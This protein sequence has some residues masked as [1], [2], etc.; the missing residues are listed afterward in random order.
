MRGNILKESNITKIYLIYNDGILRKK[1]KAKLRYMD[2]SECFFATDLPAGF[3]KPKKKIPVEIQAFT[4]DG[5]YKT[6]L[7][8]LDTN[9]TLREAIFQVTVPDTWRF[10]QL[11]NGSRMSIDLSVKVAFDDGFTIETTT[12]DVSINGFAFFD[13]KNLSSIYK[14]LP[15]TV[16]V[17]FPNGALEG[18]P[19]DTLVK[20]AKFVREEENIEYHEGEFLY[21]FKF[22]DLE[23][24]EELALKNF[25]LDLEE[26]I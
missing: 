4:P 1:Y 19:N 17:K 25:L 9:T 26:L 24:K 11:R 2:K 7:Q 23:N 5:V 21:A 12:N 18:I 15:C 14:K 22:I 16:T 3:K 20:K 10:I 6:N 13:R 8:I